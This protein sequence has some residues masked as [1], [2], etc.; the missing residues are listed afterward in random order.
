MEKP[1]D[2]DILIHAC[3]GPCSLEPVRILRERGCEPHVYFANSNIAPRSEYERRLEVIAA[4]AKDEGIEL[5]EGDY[6]PAAW[7]E[8][9]GRVGEELRAHEEPDTRARCRACYRMRFEEAAAFAREH[10]FAALGTTLS[11]SPYQHQDVIEEELERACAKA[12]IACAFEDYS[13]HY[14]AATVRSRA[15]GMYRQNYCGCRFSDE[16]AEAERAE[17][18]AL[19]EAEREARR[20][21]RALQ[22]R[23]QEAR[24]AERAA[25]DAKQARKRAVLKEM[26]AARKEHEDA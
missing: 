14:R 5:F 7:E 2:E 4:F 6:D 10:G 12:G 24:R 9:A 23:E 1:R 17:R 19:R 20:A 22:E 16:E 25:Y 18:R 15:L 26:R 3:C 13:P 21:E 8:T 11:V